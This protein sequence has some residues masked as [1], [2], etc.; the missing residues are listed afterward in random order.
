[1]ILK[2]YVT[3]ETEV[4]EV[5]IEGNI[6]YSPYSRSNTDNNERPNDSGEEGF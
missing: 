1:M 5:R 2:N 4:I 3:P 6:L